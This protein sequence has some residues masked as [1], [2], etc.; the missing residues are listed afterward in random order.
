MRGIMKISVAKGA[1]IIAAL[2]LVFGIVYGQ[3]T[4]PPGGGGGSGVAI[5]NNGSAVGSAG[6]LN[7][8]PSSGVNLTTSAPSGGVLPIHF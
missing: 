3:F 5:Q 7:M 2:L 6:T 8:I 1:S 4:P